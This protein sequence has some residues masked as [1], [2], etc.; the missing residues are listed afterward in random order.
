MSFIKIHSSRGKRWEKKQ[1][2]QG[3]FEEERKLELDLSASTGLDTSAFV[4]SLNF[5][6]NSE[7][8]ME[9]R[10]K[11]NLRLVKSIA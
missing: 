10:G 9:K 3:R 2:A 8:Q 6:I 7:N 1:K 5:Y 4:I 11:V